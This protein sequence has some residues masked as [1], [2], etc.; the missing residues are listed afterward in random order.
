MR[1]LF[2]FISLA[3]LQM[4]AIAQNTWTTIASM[5][6]GRFGSTSFSL[7]NE[8]YVIGGYLPSGNTTNEMWKYNP[9]S[10]QWT[11]LPN[12][13]GGGNYTLTSF[14]IN[15]Y[16]YVGLG[17]SNITNSVYNDF[18]KF[19]PN[20]VQWYSI[21]SLPDSGRMSSASFVINGKGYVACG[22]FHNNLYTR[23]LFEYDPA[24]NTWTSKAPLPSFGRT[25]CMGFASATDGYITGGDYGSL[26]NPVN[27][28]ETWRYTPALNSWSPMPNFPDIDSPSARFSIGNC[29]FVGFPSWTSNNI[30]QYNTQ[31]NTW[32]VAQAFPGALRAAPYA[33]VIGSTAYV[34]SG[35]GINSTY[36]TDGYSSSPSQGCNVITSIEA[37]EAT[38]ITMQG[39]YLNLDMIAGNSTLQINDMLGRVV[40]RQSLLPGNNRIDLSA[41]HGAMVATVVDEHSTRITH[42]KIFLD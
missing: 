12:Y 6:V 17:Y 27:C 4:S 37:V 31:N 10:N 30:W 11:Q 23:D 5:A 40:L 26:S 35:A 18:W 1:T 13:P 38:E 20:S 42:K 29:H 36:L 9:T 14:T 24:T 34:G 16:A 19:D 21:A 3:L 15:G 39:Q 7:N 8:G 22:D 25:F 41:Y 32:A 2:L 28:F 33:F